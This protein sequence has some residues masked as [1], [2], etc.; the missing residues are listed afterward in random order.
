VS[1]AKRTDD[2]PLGRI[3]KRGAQAASVADLLAAVVDNTA[4][5]QAAADRLLRHYDGDLVRMGGE[6]PQALAPTI[7]IGPSKAAAISAAISAAFELARRWASFAAH[8][9]S[10]VRN[11]KDIADF[12]MP[13]SRGEQQE[14]LYVVCMNAKNVITNHSPIFT[15][16]LNASLIHPRE[17]FRFAVDNSAASIIL[18]HNHPSGDPKPSKE[19]VEITQRLMDA[20]RLLEIPV[21]DHVILG[22]GTYNSP[23]DMGVVK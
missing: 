1:N 13:Y 22:D 14:V 23:K 9:N 3:T 20:G 12:F 15:G 2:G 6:S 8:G 21:L 18:V 19:D 5:A 16:T 11:S 17:V 10:P 4:D 7:G